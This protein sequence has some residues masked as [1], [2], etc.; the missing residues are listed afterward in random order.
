MG[1]AIIVSLTILI[2]FL[3]V[4][5]LI[6]RAHKNSTQVG[7]LTQKEERKMRRLL[8]EAAYV[9]KGLGVGSSIDDSDVISSRSRVA[10]DNWLVRYEDNQTKEINA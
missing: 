6:Y 5:I 9:M 8:H 2:I 10:I 4:V 7:D 1:K 3:T